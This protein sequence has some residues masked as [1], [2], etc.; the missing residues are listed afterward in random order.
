MRK[1]VLGTFISCCMVLTLLAGCSGSG[2]NPPASGESTGSTQAQ[3]QPQS[4][5]A[6]DMTFVIVP[7]TVHAW[8][9]QVNI[10]AKRQADLLS[11]QT[12]KNITID[13]RAPESADVTEQNSTLEQAAATHPDGICL[14]PVDYE[15]SKAVIEEIEARGIPVILFDAPSPEGSNLTSVGNDFA[16]QATIAADKLA[17]LIGKKGKVAVMQGAPSA[18]NH[19][20]RYQAHLDALAK[21]PDIEVIDGGIDNDSIETAKTQAAAVLAANPDLAGFLNCDAGGSGIAAP[22]EEAGKSG[23]VKFVSMDNLIEILDYVPNT[24]QAT[25]STMP[26]MQGEYAVLMMWQKA[27]GME[28]PKKVDTGIAYIDSAN[29]DEWKSIVSGK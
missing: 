4:G 11:A 9:D 15:G 21:Y 1:K 22:I 8:F 24:I 16:E 10:G 23:S 26:Q 27:N 18:P 20:Q 3:S 17:E 7:K 13:Y 12:G 25:S 14:D 28:I 29:I 2:G 19:A 6:K 5:E